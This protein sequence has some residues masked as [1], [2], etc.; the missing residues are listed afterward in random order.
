MSLFSKI[1]KIYWHFIASREKEARHLGVKIGNHCLISTRN[2]STEPYLITIGNY[3]QV[4]EDVY[5]FTH[6]GGNTVRQIDPTFDAFGKITI[7]DWA[8]I[9]AGSM[10][11][12]GVTIGEGSLI[13]AGSIVTKSVA[14]HTVVGGNPAKVICTI[15]E[16]YDRNKKYNIGTKGKS[17]QEKKEI[18][19]SLEEEKFI[20]K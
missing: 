20:K 12:P 1:S 4:T 3:V 5:F 18:I 7:E 16:Y 9:G 17:Y 14:P 11:M 8:Y 13:A 6:G 2:W 10:L 15:Q 19:L